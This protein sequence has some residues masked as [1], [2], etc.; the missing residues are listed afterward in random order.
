MRPYSGLYAC[1]GHSS[2]SSYR[3]RPNWPRPVALTFALVFDYGKRSRTVQLPNLLRTMY[4]KQ[5]LKAPIYV[6]A[7]AAL[8]CN[9]PRDWPLLNKVPLAKPQPRVG[10]QVFLPSPLFGRIS[11]WLFRCSRARGFLLE[12]CLRNMISAHKAEHRAA[13]P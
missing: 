9:H 4:Y 6:L 1:K 10:S 2:R 5:I 7:L 8:R 11:D 3:K 13:V 12:L